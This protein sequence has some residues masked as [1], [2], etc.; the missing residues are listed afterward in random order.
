MCEG[1][2]GVGGGGFGRRGLML[3]W[4]PGNP[5]GDGGSVVGLFVEAG[6]RG[7]C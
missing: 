6:G 1:D 7:G 5:N 2:G 3:R 4:G